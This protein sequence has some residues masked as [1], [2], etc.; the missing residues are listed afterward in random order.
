MAIKF[1]YVCKDDF[2]NE[3]YENSETK[4]LL[5]LID[6]KL[7]SCGNSIDGEPGF[8]VEFDEPPILLGQP[9]Q[10]DKEYEFSRMLLDRM[11]TDCDYFLGN[12]DGK[13]I[14][15]IPEFVKRMRDTHN[16]LP[17]GEKPEW[18]TMDQIDLYEI[19]M[20]W[21]VK[22]QKEGQEALKEH[23]AKFQELKPG[24]TV[25]FKRTTMK[26]KFKRLLGANNTSVLIQDFIDGEISTIDISKLRTEPHN[27]GKS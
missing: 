24:D 1:N 12:G 22:S 16:S 26:F 17:E 7:I 19:R 10:E 25:W 14:R 21:L 20:I 6:K 15:N 5:K 2:G 9:S 11:R 8:P 27:G 23:I 18:L 13:S 4:V 3:V